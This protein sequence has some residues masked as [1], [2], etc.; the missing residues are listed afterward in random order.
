[1]PEIRF[2][3]LFILLYCSFAS[4]IIIAGKSRNIVKHINIKRLQQSQFI[5]LFFII[6]IFSCAV[7]FFSLQHSYTHT[8]IHEGINII[9]LDATMLPAWWFLIFHIMREHFLNY[10]ECI[11]HNI[12]FMMLQLLLIFF[13]CFYTQRTWIS[14]WW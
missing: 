7:L 12:H 10:L 5:F 14:E 4:F 1:M 9:R 2:I 6:F 8:Y 11:K 3:F 13:C